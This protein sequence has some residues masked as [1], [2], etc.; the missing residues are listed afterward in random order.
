MIQVKP[1]RHD[2]FDGLCIGAYPDEF[3][4][5]IRK[6]VVISDEIFVVEIPKLDNPDILV[7]NFHNG[8]VKY[9]LPIDPIVVET[10][11]E[12]NSLE[13]IFNGLTEHE[14][15]SIIKDWSE[16]KKKAKIVSR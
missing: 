8:K 14:I 6:Q 4:G 7:K 16:K 5:G 1:F 12:T 11:K 3:K 9:V 13:T 2:A 10:P 15:V